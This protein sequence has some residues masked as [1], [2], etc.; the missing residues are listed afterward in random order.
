MGQWLGKSDGYALDKFDGSA[1][2]EG[3]EGKKQKGEG[4]LQWK[5]WIG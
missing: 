2:S 3:R 5:I 1:V 4:E